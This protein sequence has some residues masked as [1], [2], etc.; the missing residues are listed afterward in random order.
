MDDLS[1]EEKYQIRI[2]QGVLV[3]GLE[4]RVVGEGG[5]D[6]PWD[7]KTMGELWLKGPWITDGYYN[8]EEKTREAI[9][10]DGWFKTMDIVTVDENGYVLIA[11]RTKDIIKSGGEWISSITLE[12]LIMAHPKVAEAVVIG[13]YHPKWQER[14]VAFV[15]L[16]PGEAAEENEIIDFL[17]DKALTCAMLS[18]IH[19][20]MLLSL[21]EI[22]S[23]S[24]FIFAAVT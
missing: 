15:V 22:A 10:E 11:D 5:F 24:K 13:V 9:T 19:F 6:V 20:T 23:S 18:S 8:D 17:K 14:P 1:S 3:P 7:G 12:N 21:R 2:K 16:K 4:M